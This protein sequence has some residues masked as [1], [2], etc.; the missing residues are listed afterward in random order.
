MNIEITNSGG[1]IVFGFDGQY[2]AVSKQAIRNITMIGNDKVCMDT[3]KGVL[4]LMYIAVS[5]VVKPNDIATASLLLKTLK[6]MI[7]IPAASGQ[8]LSTQM[9]LLQQLLLQTV[10]TSQTVTQILAT[11]LLTDD[12]QQGAKFEGYAAIGTKAEETGWAIKL[13]RIK[14]GVPEEVWA[15]GRQTFINVWDDRYDLPYNRMAALNASSA[16]GKSS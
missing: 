6:D 9:A 10:P 7:G 1:C 8:D 14:N 3:G 11:P 4:E 15:N 16:N 2:I 13:T 12:T 5:D